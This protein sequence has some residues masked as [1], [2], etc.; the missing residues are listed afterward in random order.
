MAGDTT[1]AVGAENWETEVVQ[2]ETPVL[3]DFWAEWCGPCVALGPTLDEVAADFSGRL[4][5]CKVNVDKE[6]DLAV[7]FAVRSI[8]CLKLLVKGEEKDNW[9]GNMS[10]AVLTEKL[11]EKLS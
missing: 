8:P 4:K 6:R 5:V 1:V 7:K 10:K 2:S 9:V 3:I 11:N